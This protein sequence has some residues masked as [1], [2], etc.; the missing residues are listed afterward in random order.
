MA[1]VAG[2]YEVLQKIGQGGGGVVFLGKHLRLQ[3]T[4]VIKMDKRNLSV[5]EETLRRE[6]D[7]LKELNHTYIPQVYD[8]LEENGIVCTVMDYIEGESLDK[9]LERGEKHPQREVVKWACQLLEA[10]SYLHSRPPYGILHSDIKPAN[11]MLRSDGSICLI[12]YNIALALGENGAVT[13]GYSMG[14][15]SPEHYGMDYGSNQRIFTTRSKNPGVSYT[16]TSDG[17]KI[18]LDVRSDIYSLG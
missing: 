10:L 1:V 16:T 3:K 8:F 15:A 4:V 11:I 12:D 14:Y 13:V 18:L 5:G 2:T 9:V 6:V 17:K 7:I